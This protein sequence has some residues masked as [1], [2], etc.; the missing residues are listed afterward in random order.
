MQFNFIVRHKNGIRVVAGGSEVAPR[1]FSPDQIETRYDDLA[2]P[3]VPSQLSACQREARNDMDR[4]ATHLKNDMYAP[5]L[6]FALTVRLAFRQM[7][8]QPK[9]DGKKGRCRNHPQHADDW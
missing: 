3:I 4:Y 6:P 2:S 7:P 1:L 9:C 5:E 8:H